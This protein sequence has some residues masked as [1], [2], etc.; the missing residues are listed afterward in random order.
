MKKILITALIVLLLAASLLTSFACAPGAKF[1]VSNLTISPT[2]ALEGNSVLVS[3]DI[4]NSGE[5]K[6]DFTAKLKMDN[7]LTV[8]KSVSMAAGQT[9]T[10]SFILDTP[11]P[12]SHDVELN[13]LTGT[14][15]VLTPPVFANIVITPARPQV[16]DSVTISADVI[17]T[18]EVSG[19]YTV[20]LKLNGADEE[21]KTV[22]LDANT[23]VPIAFDV[24]KD[25]AGNYSVSLGN[26]TGN[27]TLLRPAAFTLS[28]LAI[29]PPQA[30][31]G[32]AVSVICSVA[33]SGEVD[34]HYPVN[35]IV[36]G[37]QVD[38][39][40]VLVPA[41]ATQSVTFSLSEETSGAYNVTVNNLF[42]T[43][44]ISEGLLPTL[45][46]GDTWVFQ[47]VDKGNTYTR[48][49]TITGEEG[50]EG[51]D[52]YVEKI[53]YDPPM[54]GWISEETQWLNK[55]NLR[56][57]VSII[58]ATLTAAGVDMMRWVI[59]SREIT[60]TEWPH[61]V[62]NNFTIDKSWKRTDFVDGQPFVAT[63]NSTVTYECTDVEDVTVAAGTFE[64][65]KIVAYENG[66]AT[67]EYWYSY[68]VKTYVKTQG[69]TDGHT[70]EL[71]SH[72]VK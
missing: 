72:S 35:L 32:Q 53:T 38:S 31:P 9:K 57:V 3:V 59:Y 49:E 23:T 43:L 46:A 64:C 17:N 58:S 15:K 68:K 14:F 47:E 45:Y 11:D 30:L 2:Q 6:G 67:T 66:Q 52:C 42:S 48:T 65:Y 8:T 25:Q 20:A 39:Q 4:T 33:N 16:G 69:I 26:L 1:E 60:G 24:T 13:D 62:G 28:S 63:G 18:G 19:N 51:K 70:T 71:L 22:E 36:N 41:G 37:V 34:G 56:T 27:F 55:A 29:L 7:A 5:A 12:G 10:I 61:E 54:D 21:T 44:V 40:D 50:M